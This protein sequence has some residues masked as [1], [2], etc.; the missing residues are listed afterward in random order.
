MSRLRVAAL[1]LAAL[2]LAGGVLV[3]ALP[4][5]R[6]VTRLFPVT[7]AAG[8]V[9]QRRV[10]ESDGKDCPDIAGYTKGAPVSEQVQ[11]ALRESGCRQA[12]RAAFTR[13]GDGI[14]V[15]LAAVR[16]AD[17]A[18]ARALADRLTPLHPALKGLALGPRRLGADADKYKIQ[19]SADGDNV[20]V[21]PQVV[22]AWLVLTT[23]T[24]GD[25]R[26]DGVSTEPLRAATEAI[27]SYF[28]LAINQG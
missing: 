27:T 6:G 15:T 14:V 24:Y 2:I 19:Y 9:D 21:P 16:L 12:L 26:D 7:F 22:G 4:R 13:G 3:T 1:T 11:A 20:V 23:A 5:A 18:A 28:T 17:P 8:G 25:G 10:A